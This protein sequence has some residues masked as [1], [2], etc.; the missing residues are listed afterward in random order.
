MSRLDELGDAFFYGCWNDTGGHMNDDKTTKPTLSHD[1]AMQAIC[2]LASARLANL[3]GVRSEVDFDH[4]EN[5][6]KEIVR[7]TG[8][9]WR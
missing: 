3:D 2:D 6:L 9:T 8:K 5:D 1:E 4:M 7:L